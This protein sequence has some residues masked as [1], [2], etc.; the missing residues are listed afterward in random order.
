MFTVPPEEGATTETVAEPGPET[1]VGVPGVPG[2]ASVTE[3]EAPEAPDVPPTF[4][5]VD[6]NVYEPP[7]VSPETTQLVAGTTTV[8]VSPP[9]L[10]VTV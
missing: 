8:Q 1:A 6:V 7:L 10:A 4:V 5:A 9:G 3:V 2:A